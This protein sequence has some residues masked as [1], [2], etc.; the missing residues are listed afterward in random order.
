MLAPDGLR[1]VEASPATL[2]TFGDGSGG[3]RGSR[4]RTTVQRESGTKNRQM[5]N[6][7][8]ALVRSRWLRL[9]A[10][11][12]AVCALIAVTVLGGN[13]PAV[14]LQTLLP[15]EIELPVVYEDRLP[16]GDYL[17]VPVEWGISEDAAETILCPLWTSGV[18]RAWSPG[19]DRV[20]QPAF[21]VA[22]CRAPTAS[23]AALAHA[24]S[25]PEEMA[26]M[27]DLRDR[28]VANMADATELHDLGADGWD[29]ACLWGSAD[30]PCRLWVFRARYG[31]YLLAVQFASVGETY[32]LGLDDFLPVVSSLDRHATVVLRPAAGVHASPVGMPDHRVCG[33]H[34]SPTARAPSRSG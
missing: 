12:L 7:R 9:G 16:S 25:G 4:S 31:Q 28:Y 10:L 15:D 19:G 29:L 34:G 1:P 17:D 22:A 21:L 18:V 3:E 11:A 14:E 26:V 13:R 33:L 2:Y 8:G 5:A 27:P 30:S 20:A 6:Y 32:G 24:L 23:L